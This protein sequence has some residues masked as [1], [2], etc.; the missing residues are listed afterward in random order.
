[1]VSGLL[2]RPPAAQQPVYEGQAALQRVL[3][4][5]RSCHRCHQFGEIEN[6]KQQ[7]AAATRGELFLLQG[8]D[9]S[10]GFDD[11]ESATIASKLKIL[12]QMSLVL[13]QAGASALSESVGSPDNTQSRGLLI[14]K[15]RME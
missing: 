5:L 10:E 12:L 11:C 4:Q 8:G 6:L 15:F 13:T 9:C 2:E 7:I 14:P 3:G 1:L